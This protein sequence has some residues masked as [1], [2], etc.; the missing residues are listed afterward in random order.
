MAMLVC[1]VK[2][3]TFVCAVSCAVS[4]KSNS[5]ACKT[6]PFVSL[7]SAVSLDSVLPHNQPMHLYSLQLTKQS[8]CC[9]LPKERCLRLLQEIIFG[10]PFD[11]YERQ[12]YSVQA[13]RVL[14]AVGLKHIPVE[15][16]LQQLSGGYKR[17]VALAVQLVRRPAVS[18]AVPPSNCCFSSS[19]SSSYSLF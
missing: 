5:H 16:P 10:W 11:E 12:A 3:T 6:C 19:C 15:T 1:C 17:R 7:P 8:S 9:C 2:S 4:H 14:E 18:N 13:H